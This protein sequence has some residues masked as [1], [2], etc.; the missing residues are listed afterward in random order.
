MVTRGDTLL[1]LNSTGGST[2]VSIGH[3]CQA[4]A[5]PLD[6]I[7]SEHPQSIS[8]CTSGSAATAELPASADSP[9]AL[10]MHVQERADKAFLDWANSALDAKPMD[11]VAAA[12][13]A[14]LAASTANPAVGAAGTRAFEMWRTT[15]PVS[16]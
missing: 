13:G 9:V 11:A 2:T 14:S 10:T 15:A 16:C 7:A 3:A 12:A 5:A 8:F 4:A 1:L 6:G